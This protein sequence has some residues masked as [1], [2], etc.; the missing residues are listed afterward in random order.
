MSTQPPGPQGRPTS[1]RFQAPPPRAGAPRFGKYEVEGQ[2]GKG[3]MGTV[4]RAR[5]TVLGRHVALK[6]L[7]A[8]QSETALAR[9]EREARTVAALRHPG[10]VTLLDAGEE[11]G[12]PFLV[13]DLVEGEPLSA[14]I[15]RGL[16]PADAA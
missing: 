2:L 8:R 1:A 5:D 6:L 10:I 11:G 14:A 9:F 13:M 7:S 16:A 4:Y 3:G 15:R 12:I